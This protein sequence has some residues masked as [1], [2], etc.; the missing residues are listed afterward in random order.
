[1]LVIANHRA[2]FKQQETWQTTTIYKE[3][4]IKPLSNNT[5]CQW[6]TRYYVKNATQ[7]IDCQMVPDDSRSHLGNC[8]LSSTTSFEGYVGRQVPLCELIEEYSPNPLKV[9]VGYPIV[10]TLIPLF[11]EFGI[12]AMCR[13]TLPSEIDHS[14]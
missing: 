5:W 13:S 3:V 8:Q 11:W 6:Q 2:R 14:R 7:E 12:I 1:F 4:T 10:A 9:V